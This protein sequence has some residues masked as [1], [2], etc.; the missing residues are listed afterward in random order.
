ML[1]L[2][3]AGL[4]DAIFLGNFVGVEALAAVNLSIPVWSLIFGLGLLISVGGSVVCGKYLGR[5]ERPTGQRDL[6]QDRAGYL[7]DQPAVLVLLNLALI[8][9]LVGA[10][11]ATNARLAAPLGTYLTILLWFTPFMML[12][13]VFFYFVRLDGQPVLAA[14]ATLVG[15]IVNIFLDW[16]LIVHLE[17]GIMG[18]AFATAMSAVLASMILFPSFLYSSVA[19]EVQRAP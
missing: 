8:D 2:S 10:L 16:L 17:M 12:Q 19:I 6:H 3:S 15:A 18:A 7:G 4:I 11:G 5:E 9:Q 14:V 13:L 1:A